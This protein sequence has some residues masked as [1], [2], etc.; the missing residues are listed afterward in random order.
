VNPP[1][2]EPGDASAVITAFVTDPQ[3][4]QDVV[5]GT[6]AQVGGRDIAV[7]AATAPGSATYT[8]PLSWNSANTAEPLNFAVDGG[9]RPYR[10]KFFDQAGNV[11]AEDVTIG[12]QCPAPGG[13]IRNGVCDQLCTQ[14]TDCATWA[15]QKGVVSYA[16]RDQLCMAGPQSTT[17]DR[18]DNVCGARQ[19]ACVSA[20][21]ITLTDAGLIEGLA[22]YGQ[23]YIAIRGCDQVPLATTDCDGDGGLEAFTTQ[24]CYCR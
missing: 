24:T 1:F 4:I 2:L 16:C 19:L 11:T 13:P 12:F 18:C 9:S 8:C 15:Q 7:F 14:P 17:P 3:G 10:V 20:S 23:C 6:L 22:Y 21:S 5:G